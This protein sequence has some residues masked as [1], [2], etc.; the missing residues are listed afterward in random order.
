M[1]VAKD[2]ARTEEDVLSTPLPGETL[3]TFYDRTKE[4]WAQKAHSSGQ[5]QNRGKEL[6][7]DGFSMAE[8]KYDEY[9]PILEEIEKIQAEAGLDA[10]ETRNAARPGGIAGG[11][12]GVDSRNR[13]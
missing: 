7:R 2:S 12:P 13:R 6:R 8:L 4:Y 11:G 5:S 3:R 1:G 10:A 9:K